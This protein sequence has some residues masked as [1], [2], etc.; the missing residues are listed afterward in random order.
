MK[1]YLK[2]NQELNQPLAECK[3]LFKAEVLDLY[4]GKLHMSCYHFCQQY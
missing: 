2:S 1:V 3:W 4:H